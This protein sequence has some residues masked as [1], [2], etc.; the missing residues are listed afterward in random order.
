MRFLIAML[1]LALA[2]LP[3]ISSAQ[4][5]E[6][7]AESTGTTVLASASSNSG[8]LG[9]MRSWFGGENSDQELLPLNEA[10]KISVRARDA[11]TLVATLTAADGYYLYRDRIAFDL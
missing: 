5:S 4:F 8:I 2:W 10:F 7:P 6:M 11:D 9:S 3:G 1:V